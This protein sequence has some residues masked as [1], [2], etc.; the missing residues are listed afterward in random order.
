MKEENGGG[1]GYNSVLDGDFLDQCT[2]ILESRGKSGLG[3]IVFDGKMETDS[4]FSEMGCTRG[5]ID[6]P[7]APVDGFCR[8]KVGKNYGGSTITS[9]QYELKSVIKK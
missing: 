3:P 2:A 8:L 4:L 1:D 9:F 5:L 7:F 6:D